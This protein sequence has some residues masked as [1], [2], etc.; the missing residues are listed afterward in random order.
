MASSALAIACQQ[1]QRATFS[2]RPQ[3]SAFV[4]V[5]ELS[6]FDVPADEPVFRSDPIQGAKAANAFAYQA[7]ESFMQQHPSFIADVRPARI[8]AAV[9]ADFGSFDR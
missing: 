1:Q 2:V 9:D 3:G 8:V 7:A 5:R 4:V 6:G